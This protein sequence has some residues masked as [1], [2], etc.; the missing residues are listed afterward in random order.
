MKKILSIVLVV[1][2]LVAVLAGCGEKKNDQPSQSAS[3][4]PPAQTSSAPPAPDT[5]SSSGTGLPTGVPTLNADAAKRADEAYAFIADLKQKASAY[6]RS[7]A[8]YRYTLNCQDPA[9]SAAGEFCYAWSDAVLVATEG[10]INIDVGVSNAYCPGGTMEALNDTKAGSIDF[11]WTLPCY[12]DGYMPLTLVI[13]NPSLGIQNATVGQFAMWELYKDNKAIQDEIAQHGEAM[14]IYANNP[15]P[16]SY[17]GNKEVTSVGDITGQIRGNKGPAQL[18]INEIGAS[19]Y[20]CPI[21][22][23]YQNV[24]TGVIDYLITDWHAIASFKLADQG[25]LN[26]YLDTNVG[27]SAYALI[28][29]D[30]VWSDIVKNGYGDAVKSVSGDFCL[31]LIGIWEA[32]EA[33]GRSDATTN[34]GT[35]YA[36]NAALAGELQTAYDN[37]AKA[38]VAANGSNAQAVYDKTLELVNK[39]NGIYK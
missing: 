3:S 6:N 26:Y 9:E 20:G 31:N 22:E 34:G 15:S 16:L 29:N 38:W 32:Y 25:V 2:M 10:A 39:Y 36:P 24:K 11:V 7:A 12:Y 19:V 27:C 14:F 17:K 28:G 37:V 21:G 35:I 30:K 8:K 33:R 5:G 1:F 18:F 4:S 13:Q 23:V